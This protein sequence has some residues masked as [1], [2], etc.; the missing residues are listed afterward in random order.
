LKSGLKKTAQQSLPVEKLVTLKRNPQYVTP[1]QMESLKASIRRDGFMAPIL[2]RADL[3][4][5]DS[6]S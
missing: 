6:K 4:R 2:V 1:R 5:A 3:S